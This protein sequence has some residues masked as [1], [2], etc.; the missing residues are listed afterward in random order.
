[1]L[2]DIALTVNDWEEIENF[3]EEILLFNMQRKFSMNGKIIQQIFNVE[4]VTDVYVM[5]H[6]DVQFEIFISPKKERKVFSHVCLAF[7]KAE[8]TYNNAVDAGYKALIKKSEGHNTYFIW[9]KSEN[10]FEIIEITK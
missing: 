6:Q 5:G 2:Q 4:G 7:W 3:Y 10:M 9:D 1:M 8:I